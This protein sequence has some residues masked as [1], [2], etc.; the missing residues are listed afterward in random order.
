MS[1]YEDLV[2]PAGKYDLVQE[3]ERLK[4][5]NCGAEFPIIDGIPSLIIDD[6]VLPAGIESPAGL[7]CMREKEMTK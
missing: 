4:C 7:K 1:K 5:V 2:C 3:G 6:A